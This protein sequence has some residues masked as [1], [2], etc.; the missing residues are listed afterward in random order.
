[1]LSFHKATHTTEHLLLQDQGAVVL[2]FKGIS[3]K[4]IHLPQKTEFT[5]IDICFKINFS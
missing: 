3:V 1:M 5:V 2:S 4:F